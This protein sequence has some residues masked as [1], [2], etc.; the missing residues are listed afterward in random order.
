[1]EREN[2][3][4]SDKKEIIKILREG[5]L[6]HIS[7]NNRGYPYTIPVYYGFEE[8]KGKIIIYIYTPAGGLKGELIRQ[9]NRVAFEVD[10]YLVSICGNGNV[11]F[12]S[13]EKKDDIL[14]LIRMR[15]RKIG[16]PFIE[17]ENVRPLLLEIAIKDITKNY[18]GVSV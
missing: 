13:E 7:M 17:Q 6:C 11:S 4:M 14:N 2:I 15:Y 1:M 18:F 16:V 12:I 5:R 9:D 3:V 8:I 10:C